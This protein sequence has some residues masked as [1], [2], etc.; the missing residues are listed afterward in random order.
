VEPPGVVQRIV[1]RR[2]QF[3]IGERLGKYQFYP[4]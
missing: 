4:F 2:K 3:S 1:H